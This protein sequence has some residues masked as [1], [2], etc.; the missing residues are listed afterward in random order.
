MARRQW[1]GVAGL[2]AT[3]SVGSLV[4]ASGMSS[5]A[6]GRTALVALYLVFLVATLTLLAG[7]IAYS[8]KW[9]DQMAAARATWPRRSLRRAVKRV[10]R[11]AGMAT[12]R[13][14][15]ATRNGIVFAARTS[16]AGLQRLETALTP[17]RRHAVL[18]ALGLQETD[19]AGA[20]ARTPPEGAIAR[21]R[22]AAVVNSPT[23][24]RYNAFEAK[25]GARSRTARPASRS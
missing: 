16:R 5:G 2:A 14:G 21:A 3:V 8:E 4:L 17:E 23:T 24:R 25:R 9:V 6:N 18:V 12:R 22:R 20:P 1:A 10:G 13:A 11:R 7:G 15:V 19:G